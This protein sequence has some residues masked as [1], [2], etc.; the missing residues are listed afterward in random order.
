M[1]MTKI[2]NVMMLM[3]MKSKGVTK[4]VRP[5]NKELHTI[6]LAYSFAGQ[7]FGEQGQVSQCCCSLEEVRRKSHE[8]NSRNCK[9]AK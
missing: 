7:V 4:V 8:V 3:T 5:G 1:I 2:G 6:I 9:S